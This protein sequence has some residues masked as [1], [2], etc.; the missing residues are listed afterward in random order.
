[1]YRKFEIF[2]LGSLKMK[3]E[4]IPYY[5]WILNHHYTI[6]N[7]MAW[8]ILV[9]DIHPL[10]NTENYTLYERI[11][12]LTRHKYVIHGPCSNKRH[13]I[14]WLLPSATL[15]LTIHTTTLQYY[16]KLFKSHKGQSI[17]YLLEIDI[18]PNAGIIY[19]IKSTIF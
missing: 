6:W 9:R 12:S 2:W 7:C 11:V 1:M 19:S 16:P 18:Y 5:K 13:V 4:T 14:E 15:H 3:Q 17:N 10:I 8:V